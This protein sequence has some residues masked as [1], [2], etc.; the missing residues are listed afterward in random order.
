MSQITALGRKDPRI[1][2][3]SKYQ[4]DG[5]LVMG[6]FE[7]PLREDFLE[8][9]DSALYGFTGDSNLELS[10]IEELACHGPLIIQFTKPAVLDLYMTC[11]EHLAMNSDNFFP[12]VK[13]I[14]PDKLKGR[15]PSHWKH[16]PL[17]V[18]EESDESDSETESEEEEEDINPNT[19]YP[20]AH[21][22][23]PGMNKGDPLKVYHPPPKGADL[24][25][26][27]LIPLADLENDPVINP[28]ASSSAPECIACD[29]EHERPGAAHTH[30]HTCVHYIPD[31]Y[32][33]PSPTPG[34]PVYSPTSPAYSPPNPGI[35]P[36]TGKPWFNSDHLIY[37]GS[38][39]E[40]DEPMVAVDP[41]PLRAPPRRSSRRPKKRRRFIEEC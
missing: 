27:Q 3:T 15:L 33:P 17:E 37:D 7:H 2:R 28:P 12:V 29:F 5:P 14:C 16:C 36:G 11:Y 26:P 18:I 1:P 35:N 30:M 34:S 25:H 20:Y 19:M 6:T 23:Y 31:G 24:P 8:M 9:M 40:D 22:M 4:W 32:S 38:D 21:P 41:A 13:A 39:S 10:Q